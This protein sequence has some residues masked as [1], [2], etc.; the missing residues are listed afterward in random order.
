MPEELRAAIVLF[1][2][3]LDER[4]SGVCLPASNRSSAGGASP[5]CS[6]STRRP[7]PRAGG[8]SST[9]MS[10]SPG[11]ARGRRSDADGKKTPEVIARIEA[12]MTHETPATPSAV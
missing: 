6:A 5:L 8:S 1:A 4:I 7:S 11:A 9:A 2:S 3:L 10:R 12:L